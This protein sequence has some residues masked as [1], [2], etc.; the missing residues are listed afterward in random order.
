MKAI[1]QLR[2]LLPLI[3][4]CSSFAH[5]LGMANFIDDILDLIEIG[6]VVSAHQTEGTHVKPGGLAN[7][8]QQQAVAN[9]NLPH[10]VLVVHHTYLEIF[11]FTELIALSNEMTEDFLLQVWSFQKYWRH[12]KIAKWRIDL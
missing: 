3:L 1:V 7:H 12:Q 4:I 8:Y 10:E 2:Y 6:F 9:L 11:A 5:L